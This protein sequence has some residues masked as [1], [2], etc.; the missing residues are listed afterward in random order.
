MSKYAILLSII[1]LW[2]CKKEEFKPI[3]VIEISEIWTSGFSIEW[4]GDNG[5]IN[6][7]VSQT[8]SFEQLLF[9]TIVSENHAEVQGFTSEFSFFMRY[10]FVDGSKKSRF[11]EAFPL[12]TTALIAPGNIFIGKITGDEIQLSWEDIKGVDYELQVS[13]DLSFNNLAEGYESVVFGN[14]DFLIEPLL[15]LT[16]YFIRLR[17][18]NQSDRS[19]WTVSEEV[20]TTDLLI[21]TFR[22]NDFDKGG[23]IPIQFTCNGASPELHWKNAP[24]GTESFAITM[25]DLDFQNGFNHWILFNI[26]AND[27]AVPLGGTGPNKP[28][29][30]TEG[31]NDVGSLGYFGPCP[32]SGETHRYVFNLYALNKRLILND[33]TRIDQFLSKIENN[34]LAVVVLRGEYE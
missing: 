11:S 5:G 30:S 12:Q 26:S 29:G 27:R 8:E 31:T 1:I 9:D 22:S 13:T 28:S 19:V 10:R 2:S 16:S 15:P 14:N 21:F 6:I 34:I 23:K 32:P 3:P 17:S 25:E 7:Q 33:N 4:Q 18:I 20:Q 24:E